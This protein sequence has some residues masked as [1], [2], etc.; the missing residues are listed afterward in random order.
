MLKS[1]SDKWLEDVTG[2]ISSL[3]MSLMTRCLITLMMMLLMLL[4]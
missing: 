4:G 3:T 2:C 1:T